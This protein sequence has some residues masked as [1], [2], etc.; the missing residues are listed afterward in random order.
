VTPTGR[1]AAAPAVAAAEAEEPCGV[2]AIERGSC[3]RLLASLARRVGD[4]APLAPSALERAMASARRE[5]ALA[6]VSADLC[7]HL[8][9][10]ESRARAMLRPEMARA[11]RPIG[12]TGAVP[13]VGRGPAAVEDAALPREPPAEIVIAL[14]HAV[15]QALLRDAHHLTPPPETRWS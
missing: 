2:E 12:G 14:G 10:H 4:A 7:A 5:A 15:P 3:G 6:A 13:T 9:R 8:E 11:G 1:R